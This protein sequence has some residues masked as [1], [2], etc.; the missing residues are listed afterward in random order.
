MSNVALLAVLLALVFDARPVSAATGVFREQA[1]PG[2]PAGATEVVRGPDGGF[3]FTE[4]AA[5]KIG[6]INADGTVTEFSIPTANA[7]PRGIGGLFQPC[8]AEFGANQIGCVE[9]GQVIERRLPNPD[10]GPQQRRFH[11]RILDS[12]EEREPSRDRTQ[13]LQR[14]M[15]CGVRCRSDRLSGEWTDHRAWFDS[16]F[17]TSGNMSG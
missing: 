16:R 7:I 2:S 12:N 1:I 11:N 5:N 14:T 13:P 9:N 15:F 8:F 4:S 10:S 3:W 17:R 6:R